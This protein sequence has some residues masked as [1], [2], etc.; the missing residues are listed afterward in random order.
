MIQTLYAYNT[1]ANERVLTTAEKLTAAQI[2]A[3]VIADFPSIRD[4]LAHILS[5]QRTWLTHA[6]ELTPLSALN[7][8]DFADLKSLRQLWDKVEADTKAFVGSLDDST[9]AKTIH[10][11]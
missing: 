6:R 11:V 3:P 2:A 5:A 4:L 10:Y 9:L 8:L 1:W 7:R